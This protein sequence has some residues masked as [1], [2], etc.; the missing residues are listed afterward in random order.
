MD[1]ALATVE[2]Q[3][4]THRC[5]GLEPVELAFAPRGPGGPRIRGLFYADHRGRLRHPDNQPHVPIEFTPPQTT[6][7]YRLERAWLEAA[8]ALA[9]EMARRGIHGELTFSP[10]ILDLR[11]WKWDHF[12]VTPRFTNFIDFPFTWDQADRVVRQQS[13]KAARAGFTCERTDDF[14]RVLE[15]LAGSQRRK[16]FVYGISLAD[17]AAARDVLGAD[18]LRMYLCTA[19]DGAPATARV[20]VHRPGGRAL[21]WMAGTLPAYLNSGATQLLLG[22]ALQDLQAAGATGHNS[23]GA[24]IE[25]VAHTKL[26]WGGR[27]VPQ[28]S[29]QA[30]DLLALRRLA[31]G[32][33]R[34][35]RHRRELRRRAAQPEVAP[36]GAQLD[37]GRGAP[38]P[39]P[40]GAVSLQRGEAAGPQRGEPG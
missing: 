20:M 37:R 13:N 19:P 22:H 3:T 28:Y 36:A 39:H 23:C 30:Y 24:D 34:Y 14:S 17:L 9:D 38:A 5:W 25:P 2:W 18:M 26:L 7:S 11:P 12:R 16:G 32:F 27:V 1:T 6:A 40:E 4:F 8:R 31:G 29:I 15:C 33:V 21:D 35:V 10:G